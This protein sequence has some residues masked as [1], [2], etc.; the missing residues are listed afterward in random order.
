M[1]TVFQWAD[2]SHRERENQCCIGVLKV[3][4]P[5]QNFTVGV[6]ITVNGRP[7]SRAL[8]PVQSQD[9]NELA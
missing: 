3:V 4:E 1:R 7:N 5:I 8:N 9:K 6:E 2:S